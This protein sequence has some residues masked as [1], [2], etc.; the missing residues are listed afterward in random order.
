MLVAGEAARRAQKL[1]P[2]RLALWIAGV[3]CRVAPLAQ[4][5]A[6]ADFREL[7]FL[8]LR[9]VLP[10][11]L[12]FVFPHVL[13]W[14]DF[15]L[16]NTLR[17]YDWTS[18]L[19]GLLYLRLSQKVEWIDSLNATLLSPRVLDAFSL[20]GTAFGA[21]LNYY[22]NYYRYLELYGRCWYVVVG[23][24]PSYLLEAVFRALEGQSP[25]SPLSGLVKRSTGALVVQVGYQIFGAERAE[26]VFVLFE[27]SERV[28][29]VL[30][31]RG[32]AG[33]IQAVLERFSLFLTKFSE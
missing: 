22:Y 16:V 28:L 17:G 20:V 31:R 27:L 15:S 7:A 11:L 2:I 10:D 14:P 29:R 19:L 25:G 26:L 8:Y 9:L 1:L 32:L 4:R 3:L 6:E 33:A 13:F 5:V 18:P 30:G 12:N 24:V 21:P 23:A